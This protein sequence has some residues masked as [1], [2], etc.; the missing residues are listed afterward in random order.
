M[1][2][3][4]NLREKLLD[5]PTESASI[6]SLSRNPQFWQWTAAKIVSYTIDNKAVSV[7][8]DLEQHLL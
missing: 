8:S 3:K 6:E 5:R 4:P 2:R 7:A 1:S